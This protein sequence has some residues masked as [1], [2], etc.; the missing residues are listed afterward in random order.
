MY[1]MSVLDRYRY[2]LRQL[3][4]VEDSPPFNKRI[5]GWPPYLCYSCYH[6]SASNPASGGAG[7]CQTIL[8]HCIFFH[9]ID[10]GNNWNQ[11]R[12]S[13]AQ[14]VVIQ[15]AQMV[16]VST[17]AEQRGAGAIC[18]QSWCVDH[19]YCGKTGKQKTNAYQ[20]SHTL[21]FVPCIV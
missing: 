14:V 9:S 2:T 7:R 21:L 12:E 11:E 1:L 16:V 19:S 20:G 6:D 13:T 5:C 8:R 18:G 3:T 17:A 10:K 4:Q 15:I